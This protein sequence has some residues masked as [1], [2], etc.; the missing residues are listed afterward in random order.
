[1]KIWNFNN[2]GQHMN[3]DLLFCGIFKLKPYLVFFNLIYN[4]L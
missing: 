3:L 1:M 2:Y 4:L